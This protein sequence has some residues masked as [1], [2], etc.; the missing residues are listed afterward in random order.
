M[1]AF[2]RKFRLILRE[3]SRSAIE[4]AVVE[5]TQLLQRACKQAVD[6]ILRITNTVNVADFI[7]IVS[8]DWEFYDRKFR[9]NELD[10]D[11]GIEVKI[12]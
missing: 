3:R 11:F 2:K 8:G 10:D 9:G 12:V 7:A 6:D 4:A 1:R 5:Q